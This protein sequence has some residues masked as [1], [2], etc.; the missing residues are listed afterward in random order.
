MGADL[1]GIKPIGTAVPPSQIKEQMYEI[2]VTQEMPLADGS[3]T[4][5]VIVNKIRITKAQ[6]RQSITQAQK[7]LDDANAKLSAI[8]TLEN[9][10]IKPA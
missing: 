3:G 10:Q 4:A 9:S 2:P 7:Q 1:T 8:E 6:L 5:T